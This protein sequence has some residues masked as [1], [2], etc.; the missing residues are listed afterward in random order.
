[1]ESDEWRVFNVQGA[2]VG[3]GELSKDNSI[4]LELPSGLYFF[5]LGQEV[6]KLIIE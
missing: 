1:L 5:Q 4:S 2:V 6:Q 3:K